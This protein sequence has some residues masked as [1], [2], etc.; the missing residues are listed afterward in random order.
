MTE[1]PR[2]DY[3]DVNKNR[4]I[5]RT[6]KEQADHEKLFLEYKREID[7]RN[8][9]NSDNY[10]RSILTLSAQMLAFT[11]AGLSFFKVAPSGLLIFGWALLILAIISTILSFQI[12]Q[13]VLSES[14]ESAY[15]YHMVGIEEAASREGRFDKFHDWLGYASGGFFSF[16]IVLIL[17]FMSTQDFRSFPEEAPVIPDGKV[18]L[19]FESNGSKASI[20]TDSTKEEKN[21]PEQREAK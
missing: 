4:S 9:G 5:A 10:D 13:R 14:L 20:I 7:R 15:D 6:E 17:A 3:G 11:F 21:E 19:K 1:E 16:G 8:A 12:S 18:E 2:D